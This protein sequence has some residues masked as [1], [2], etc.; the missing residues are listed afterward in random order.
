MIDGNAGSAASCTMTSMTSQRSIEA[1][2]VETDAELAADRA[3]GAVA[4][5]HE[6]DRA[7]AA[8]PAAAASAPDAHLDVRE[9]RQAL[10]QHRVDLWL[11]EDVVLVPA[12]QRFALEALERE[13]ACAVR[14]DVLHAGRHRQQVVQLLFEA[15]SLEDRAIS[16]SRWHA[17]GCGYG[18]VDRSIDERPQAEHPAEVG[19]RRAGGPEAHDRRRR[20][21]GFTPVAIGLRPVVPHVIASSVVSWPASRRASAA[22]RQG[23]RRTRPAAE[24][25]LAVGLGADPGRRR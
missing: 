17:R 1:E 20:R 5:D 6:L 24:R 19:E 16:A 10:A 22:R 12:E 9:A 11:D 23:R 18:A 8:R 15:Q 21:R 2:V 4:P 7:H 14:V 3:A 25:D 13:Q